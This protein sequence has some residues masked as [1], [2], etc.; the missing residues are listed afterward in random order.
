MKKETEK[1]LNPSSSLNPLR[2]L[3]SSTADI[4][5]VTFI[6]TESEAIQTNTETAVFNV[7]H[8]R[9]IFSVIS[10]AARMQPLCPELF[11]FAIRYIPQS[12]AFCF[13]LLAR[14]YLS[15]S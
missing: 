13:Q 5:K 10:L 3:R 4:T 1:E 2:S 14:D 8:L 11:L 6:N 15:F 12:F 7:R 9:S